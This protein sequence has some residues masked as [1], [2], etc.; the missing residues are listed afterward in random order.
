M[1]YTIAVTI[2]FNKKKK[3][4]PVRINN[5]Y[6]YVCMYVC[7]TYVCSHVDRQA[8]ICAPLVPVQISVQ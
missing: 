4:M 8:D 2:S 3:Y 1:K 5:I 6:M 7:N